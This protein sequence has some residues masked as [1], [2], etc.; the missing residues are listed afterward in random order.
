VPVRAGGVNRRGRRSPLARRIGRW[1]LGWALAA[2][3]PSFA[4]ALLGY[5]FARPLAVVLAV[6]G[7]AGL[8]ICLGT[9][10]FDNDGGA[11]SP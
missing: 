7:A 3:A 5:F 1:D 2:N 6:T 10:L 8:A 9:A 11:A 4:L